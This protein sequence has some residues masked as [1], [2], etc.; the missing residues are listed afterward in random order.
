VQRIMCRVSSAE[1]RFQTISC[2]VS[3]LEYPVHSLHIKMWIIGCRV[4]GAE[5]KV[6][7][8]RQR[9]LGENQVQSNRCEVSGAEYLV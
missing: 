1:N 3:G 7:S 5:Y 4:P 9:K 2:I 8:I 6:Q